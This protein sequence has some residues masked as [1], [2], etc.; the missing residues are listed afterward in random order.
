M[1][2]K[3]VVVVLTVITLISTAAMAAS[4][5]STPA[6]TTIT[7]TKAESISVAAGTLPGFNLLSLAPQSFTITSNYNLTPQRNTVTICAYMDTTTGIMKGTGTNTDTIPATNVQ[8]KPTSGSYAVINGA[9]G[10]GLTSVT[11]V[12]TYNLTNQAS[13]KNVTNNDTLNIQLVGVDPALQADTYT[14]TITV[15]AYAQ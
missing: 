14:G 10:C 4:L 7:A 13:R 3:W 1:K 12:N 6:T 15:V 9:A 8:A 11:T 5:S 2:T